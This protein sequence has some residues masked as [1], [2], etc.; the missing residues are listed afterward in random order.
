LAIVGEVKWKTRL[1]KKELRSVEDKLTSL[2]P[3]RGFLI[4]PDKSLLPR[5]PEDIDVLDWKNFVE[6]SKT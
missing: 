4:V 3:E 1:T 6:L 2:D 5:E